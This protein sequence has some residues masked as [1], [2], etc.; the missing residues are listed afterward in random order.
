MKTR[1]NNLSALWGLYFISPFL[2]LLYI[3]K[4]LN[5]NNAKPILIGIGVFYASV[6]VPIPNSDAVRIQATLESKQ[7]YSFNEY[8]GDLVGM[9]EASPEFKDPY[10]PTVLFVN[11][12]LGGGL[13]SFRIIIGFVYFYFFISLMLSIYNDYFISENKSWITRCI[14]TF[15]IFIIPIS[16]GLNGVRWPTALIILLYGTY[17]LA[18]TNQLKY[19]ILTFMSGLV[20]FAIIPSLIV[21]TLITFIPWIRSNYFSIIILLLSIIFSNNLS[22]FFISF[23]SVTET[24]EQS[25][26][27]YI[28]EGYVDKRLQRVESW[29]WYVGIG[30]YWP[31]QLCTISIVIFSFL[32]NKFNID[33]LSGRIFPLSI[34]FTVLAMITGGILDASTN[35]FS[36]LSEFFVLLFMLGLW[37]SNK[38]K[39]LIYIF[40]TAF[41]FVYIFK[42]YITL[43]SDFQTIGI[44]FF[45]NPIIVFL[46]NFVS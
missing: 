31:F 39:K 44:L 34:Y 29:N 3:I 19:F 16:G 14:F 46:F 18:T 25:T 38:N 24:L 21:V 11:T 23:S 12:F 36:K 40:I 42:M 30:K 9:F 26:S 4:N 15:L 37:Q 35:R 8:I 32:K 1:K 45:S 2:T 22:N 13:I 6:F 20:H 41:L 5:I 43:D 28:S 7:E 17:K 27:S 33:N 10:F